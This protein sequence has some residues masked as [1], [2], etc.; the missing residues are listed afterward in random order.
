VEHGVNGFVFH[1]LSPSALANTIAYACHVYREQPRDFAAMQRFAMR[2]PMGWDRAAS[3]YE[4]L[5][6][7][8][9]R[10]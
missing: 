2:K 4:A 1:E 6:R 10:A 5:Y 8:A 9:L 7:L 3:Q